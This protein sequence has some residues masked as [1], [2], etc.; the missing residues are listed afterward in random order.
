MIRSGPPG[1]PGSDSL[2]MPGSLPNP[3]NEGI[4][5]SA[6]RATGRPPVNE[7]DGLAA[8]GAAGAAART[9]GFEAAFGAV[10]LA[11][12]L[13][14][15]AGALRLAVLFFAVVFLAVDRFAVLFFAVVRLAVDFLPPARLAVDFFAVDFFLV[16]DFFFAGI[17]PPSDARC[18][19]RAWFMRMRTRGC[20]LRF[21]A[22]ALR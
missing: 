19:V 8:A 10:A 3:P 18:K 11:G 5:G 14:R 16:E 20:Y 6:G 13:F 2:P 22:S 7:L 1:A 9:A 4:G 17:F 12:A 15:L 21:I